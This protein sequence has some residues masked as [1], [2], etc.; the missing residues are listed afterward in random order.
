MKCGD[1]YI[2][3]VK[4]TDFDYIGFSTFVPPILIGDTTTP[5][6][7]EKIDYSQYDSVMQRGHKVYL[8]KG[9]V[10]QD[11]IIRKKPNGEVWIDNRRFYNN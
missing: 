4:L 7:I 11:W 5:P 1:V 3:T 10:K 8:P 6:P 9:T 2:A